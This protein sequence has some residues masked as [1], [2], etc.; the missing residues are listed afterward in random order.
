MATTE[1]IGSRRTMRA[2]VQDR[3]GPPEVL[4]PA[5]VDVPVPADDQVLVRVV[6]SSVNAL[7]WH[8][9]RGAPVLVRLTDGLRRPRAR[10]RGVD[11]AGRVEAVGRDVTWA[12]PGDEVF[13]ARNGAFAEYVAGGTFAPKPAN[14]SFE[15]AA[16]IP[17]AGFTALQAV[18]DHG[19][20]HPGHRVLVTGAGGGVGS[21]AV[22]IA[23]AHGAHVTAETGAD[24][25]AMVAALGAD[26]VVDRGVEDVT[27]GGDRFDAI[28]DVA[29]RAALAA[30]GRL[31]AK[32]GILVVVGAAGDGRGLG[33]L[34]RPVAA[35]LRSR[36]GSRRMVPFVARS[37]R[38]DLLALGELAAAGA[39]R[40]VLDRTY[41][42]DRV[43]EAI[44]YLETGRARGKVVVTI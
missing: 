40:P 41:P 18:R 37:N 28:V 13:G 23:K 6:A 12:K 3:Y 11:V 10:I 24:R 17:I 20:V 15:E 44:G 21:L 38:D 30:L 4:R 25:V 8:T 29:G 26:R 43:G 22:Q 27:Q 1:G 33:T 32:G 2:M 39:L 7:D 19:R 14:L 16:A 35:V 34:V 36:L 42:L 5:E 31:L 9:M